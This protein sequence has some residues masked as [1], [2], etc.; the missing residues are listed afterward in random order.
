MLSKVQKP[1]AK[2]ELIKALQS[3]SIQ[4]V[5]VYEE[6]DLNLLPSKMDLIRQKA[7]IIIV[8]S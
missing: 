1:R 6:S 4:S 2:Q 3:A 5:T 7:S 8:R